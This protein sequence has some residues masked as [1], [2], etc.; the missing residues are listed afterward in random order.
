MTSIP[1][2][3]PMHRRPAQTA[4]AVSE[5]EEARFVAPFR[6]RRRSLRS[7]RHEILSDSL[8]VRHLIV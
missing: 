4:A 2:P 3:I 8:Y 5:V 1:V 7:L 6:R